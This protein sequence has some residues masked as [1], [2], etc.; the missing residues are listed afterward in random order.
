MDMKA[1]RTPQ[2][3]DLAYGEDSY[4]YGGRTLWYDCYEHGKDDLRIF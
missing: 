1:R 4:E 2:K 3:D